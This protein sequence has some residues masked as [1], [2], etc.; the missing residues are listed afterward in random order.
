MNAARELVE[1]ARMPVGKAQRNAQDKGKQD[2]RKANLAHVGGMQLA[3]AEVG[4]GSRRAGG[5]AQVELVHRPP[6]RKDRKRRHKQVNEAHHHGGQITRDQREQ[7]GKRQSRDKVEECPRGLE[8]RE[9]VHPHAAAPHKAQP[10]R[11]IARHLE[12]RALCDELKEVERARRGHEDERPPDQDVAHP[13]R[14][15]AAQGARDQEQAH[16]AA[17]DVGPGD[18]YAEVGRGMQVVQVVL[19][20]EPQDGDADEGKRE[21]MQE[22]ASK[23]AGPAAH[24]V[25]ALIAHT[26]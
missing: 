8:A 4:L 5:V 13:R 1:L 7:A 24:T 26:L 22:V 9:E 12:R 21:V 14:Q 2:K 23:N 19:V 3:V 6:E 18:A 17:Q 16:G 10:A 11:D 15:L 25:A 20:P